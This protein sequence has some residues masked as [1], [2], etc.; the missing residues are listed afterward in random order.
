MKEITLY[1]DGA[2]SGN[3][4]PGGCGTVLLFGAHRKEFSSGYRL[5]TNNRMEILSVIIGLEALNQPCRV[6]LY[7]DSRYVIDAVAKG[8][9]KRWQANNWM[10][11]KKDAALNTDLW[12]RLLLLLEKHEVTCHWVK[13]HAG[14]PENER[15]DELARAAILRTD[16]WQDDVIPAT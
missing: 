1:T 4:G 15:C 12:A 8:W 6:A 7:S 16:E 10:R 5:T 2:C 14:N 9:A 11:T 13:G 3:P